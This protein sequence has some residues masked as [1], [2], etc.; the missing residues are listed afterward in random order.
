MK[1]EHIAL[2]LLL[3]GAAARSN[4]SLCSSA[5]SPS[6]L[7]VSAALSPTTPGS[8]R[9]HFEGSYFGYAPVFGSPSVAINGDGITITIPVTDTAN[10]STPTSPPW[11]LFCS[12]GDVELGPIQPGAYG[13]GLLHQL[14]VGGANQGLLGGGAGSFV[15]AANGMMECSN[16][17]T[18]SLAPSAPSIHSPIALSSTRAVTGEFY[19]TTHSTSGTT[20]QVMD[21]LTT[22]AP[23]PHPL[24]C[25]TTRVDL[26]TLPAGTYDVLWQANDLGYVTIEAEGRYQFTVAST[27]VDVPAMN[28]TLL[29]FLCGLLA[30]AGLMGVRR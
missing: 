25:L 1:A 22:E 19:G 10:P 29:V 8:T 13:V 28:P 17:R 9:L 27:M 11:S 20:I 24:H 26:G 3:M 23:F 5:S 15:W 21:G 18:F 7:V 14:T 16:T 2:L 6:Q 30:V 12:S 4:A